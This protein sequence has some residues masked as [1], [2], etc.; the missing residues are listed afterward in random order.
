M[1]GQQCMDRIYC[2]SKRCRVPHTCQE[3]NMKSQAT[4]LIVDDE[5]DIRELLVLTLERMQIA[6]DSA[7][8]IAEAK[9]M[10]ENRDY[11]LCLTDM[12]LPDGNGLDLV[13]YITQ[14]KP[15]VPVA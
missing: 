3:R 9:I 8:D 11:G 14:L 2:P 13:R 1:R 7:S 6:T 10:L 5:A 12:K 15:G 4:C